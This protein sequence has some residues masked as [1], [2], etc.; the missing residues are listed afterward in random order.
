MKQAAEDDEVGARSARLTA[1]EVPSETP[2]LVVDADVLDRNLRAMADSARV[3]SLALRPH[4]KTHKCI[5]I[6]LRQL[7][8]GAVGVTV[9]TVTEPRSSWPPA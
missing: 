2:C 3:R 8:L 5:E 1:M 6:A 9:A 7:E 4:A